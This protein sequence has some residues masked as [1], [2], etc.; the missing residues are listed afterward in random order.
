[1]SAGVCYAASVRANHLDSVVLVTVRISHIMRNALT[2]FAKL[3]K[4]GVFAVLLF[5]PFSAVN[6]VIAYP[7]QKPLF[8][9]DPWGHGGTDRGGS[10]GHVQRMSRHRTFM[11]DGVPSEY[12][13]KLNPLAPT[14]GVIHEGSML[15]QQHCADCH[16]AEGMGDGDAAN[17]VN[18]PPAFLAY[19]IQR[20]QS[21]DEYLMWTISEGGTVF[22][23]AMPVFKD[24][25][26][27]L[28]IWKIITFMRAGFPQSAK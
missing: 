26:S 1:M 11:N 8:S 14:H 13:G 17:S 24:E 10:E 9:A 5:A 28:A 3:T 6:T 23:T 18:P 4:L 22:G 21:V 7:D 27:E 25:L 16:G 19:L 2:K 15:Y 20:P 12:R